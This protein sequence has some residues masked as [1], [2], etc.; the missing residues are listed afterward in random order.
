MCF[1]ESRN[2]EHKTSTLSLTDH[3]CLIKLG[4]NGIYNPSNLFA[5]MRLIS[6]RHVTEFSPAKTGEYPRLVSPNQWTNANAAF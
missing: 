6:T 5:R 2:F 4:N 3:A 1:K